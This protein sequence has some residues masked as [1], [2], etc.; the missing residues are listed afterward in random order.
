MFFKFKRTKAKREYMFLKFKSTK[1]R[2]AY[3]GS[4]FIEIQ[5]CRLPLGTPAQKIVNTI[6]HWDL[7]SLYIYDNHMSDFY[8]EYKNILN[9]G[10]YYNMT[11][12]LV[13]SWGINYYNEEK[14]KM[15]IEKLKTYKPTGF[16]MF[17]EWLN[18]NPY[19]NGFYVLGV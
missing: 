15:I 11:E 1:E 9:N 8:D 14:T 19:H 5:Y 13:D 18:E 10:L 2:R 6:T 17:L 12:G 4:C 7:T 16:E 3:G